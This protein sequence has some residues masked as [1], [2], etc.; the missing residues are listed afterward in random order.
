[1][2]NENALNLG[3]LYRALTDAC[4]PRGATQAE[5]MTAQLH[6]LKS[7]CMKLAAA[8]SVHKMTPSLDSVATKVLAGVPARD[9]QTDFENGPALDVQQRAQFMLGYTMGADD[10]YVSSIK[11]ARQAAG[12]TVRG[13]AA[14]VGVSPSTIAE[15]EAGRKVPRSDTLKKI[16]DACG[17]SMDQVWPSEDKKC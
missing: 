6:P 7:V 16:A 10:L 15:I 5:L 2:T 1:M 8:H 3:R 13:L 4:S 17:V 12:L 11:A 9:L 14:K